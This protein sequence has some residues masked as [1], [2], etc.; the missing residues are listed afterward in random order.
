MNKL[1]ETIVKQLTKAEGAIDGALRKVRRPVVE[2]WIVPGA[3]SISLGAE[4][5]SL[6]RAADITII[7]HQSDLIQ[8]LGET[9]YQFVE[10]VAPF[11]AFCAGVFGVAIPAGIALHR[12]YDRR[13]ITTNVND[14]N[15]F[16]EYYTRAKIFLAE[17]KL[18][19][20]RFVLPMLTALG[21]LHFSLGAL[22][23]N[24][25]GPAD[26][27]KAGLITGLGLVASKGLYDY[28]RGDI[29]VT[30]A[31]TRRAAKVPLLYALSAVSVVS[32]AIGVAS[33]DSA[34]EVGLLSATKPLSASS[35][36]RK[37]LGYRNIGRRVMTYW[38]ATE[39]FARLYGEDTAFVRA[40]IHA[41]SDF[42]HYS[43]KGVLKSTMGAYGLG[44][45]TEVNVAH[46]NELVDSGKLVG[47]RFNWRRVVSDPAENIRATVATIKSLRISLCNNQN[48]E[49]CLDKIVAAYIAGEP[50]IRRALD[51][52]ESDNIWDALGY[53][54]GRARLSTM[55]HIKKVMSYYWVL[56]NGVVWPTVDRDINSY[57]GDTRTNGYRTRIHRGI[58]I[59]PISAGVAGDPVLAI[60]NGVV[61]AAGNSGGSE[62]F[63]VKVRHGRTKIGF[64]SLYLHG[65]K[66]SIVVRTGQRIRRGEKLMLM[67]N[68]GRSTGVH[69]HLATLIEYRFGDREESQYLDPL[70]F[71]RRHGRRE[72]V[73]QIR[74]PIYK[75]APIASAE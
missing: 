58:D 57:Y 7:S 53:I 62:G 38:D 26:Y 16:T 56:K 71:Y 49:E 9:G 22:S 3:I 14:R 30:P 32:T 35:E 74:Q 52:V 51:E 75:G 36:G 40:L 39:Y 65:R 2:S 5:L 44:Q 70:D 8:R 20:N 59:A 10:A 27:L 15:I 67:G 28:F 68:T 72:V 47:E 37:I 43:G 42:L 24:T 66:G 61:V 13:S 48:S 41:E 55:L 34:G 17:N 64:H 25:N 31:I 33:S 19:N 6:A 69:L 29:P 50:A 21:S 23:E 12:Y 45:Q 46:L 63:Y 4:A 18:V 1:L 73:V 11:G 60:G 54:G